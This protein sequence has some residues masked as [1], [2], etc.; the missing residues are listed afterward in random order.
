MRVRHACGRCAQL[1]FADVDIDGDGDN[2]DDDNADVVDTQ[3][4]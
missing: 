2:S 3:P 1:L 4:H